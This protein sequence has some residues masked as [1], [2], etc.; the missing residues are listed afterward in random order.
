MSEIRAL[1]PIDWNRMI[2]K[3]YLCGVNDKKTGALVDL[4]TAAQCKALGVPPGV[5]LCFDCGWLT[6]EPEVTPDEQ[7]EHTMKQV[8][9][10]MNQVQSLKDEDHEWAADERKFGGW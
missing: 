3:C 5:S 6:E 1:G 7:F 4:A 10:H 8:D 2:R 9:D